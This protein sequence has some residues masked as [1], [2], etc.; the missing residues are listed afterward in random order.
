VFLPDHRDAFQILKLVS[1]SH[2]A[3]AWLGPTLLNL[4]LFVKSY[5]FV[6]HLRH[7]HRS[8]PQ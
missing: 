6:A 4:A 2:R 1:G 5:D 3:V 8:Q 7:I